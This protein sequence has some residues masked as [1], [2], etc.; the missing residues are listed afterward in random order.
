V[1][2][3]QAGGTPCTTNGVDGSPCDSSNHTG[4]QTC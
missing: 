2:C 3:P 4:C 1:S